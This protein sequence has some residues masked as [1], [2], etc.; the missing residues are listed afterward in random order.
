[1]NLYLIRHTTPMVAPGVCYGQS[2]VGLTEQFHLEASTVRDKLPDMTGVP[3]YSSPLLRC[4]RLAEFLSDQKPRIDARLM[5]MHFGDW[6]GQR[7]ADIDPMAL[8]HW[9]DHYVTE[10]PPNGEAMQVLHER[11]TRFYA[12][13]LTARHADVL[14]V[15]HGGV[16]RT[17]LCHVLTLPLNQAFTFHPDFASVTQVRVQD[18][19]SKIMGVN[20]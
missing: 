16:I 6:E 19:V 3:V 5:E 20:R 1:M 10:G 8:R 17:L 2:D 14:V 13:L 15:T 9:G 18:G 7:W 11:C 12:E 4:L